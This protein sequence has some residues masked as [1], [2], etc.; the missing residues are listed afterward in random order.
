MSD[1]TN[2]KRKYTKTVATSSNIKHSTDS[3]DTEEKPSLNN[4]KEK[5]ESLC[6]KKSKDA[7][8]LLRQKFFEDLKIEEEFANIEGIKQ[9]KSPHELSS[10]IVILLRE[11]CAM[12]SQH[13]S[14]SKMLSSSTLPELLSVLSSIYGSNEGLLCDKWT[15]ME[16]V[17][18]QRHMLRAIF[19]AC[20]IVITQQN[21]VN[22]I[23]A[24]NTIAT[25]LEAASETCR[26]VD[27]HTTHPTANSSSNLHLQL[28]CDMV[29]GTLM[30]IQS[31]FQNLPFN[32]TLINSAVNLMT[33]FDENKGFVLLR[34]IFSKVDALKSV[35]GDN[36]PI[37]GAIDNPV[38]CLS[39]LI[40]TLKVTK[41]TYIHTIKCLKR[42]HRKCL[43]SHYF[44]HHHD[45]LGVAASSEPST[46][47]DVPLK[48][49]VHQTMAPPKLKCLVATWSEFLFN[50]I[51][52]VTSK[53]FQVQ[54]LSAAY[55]SGVCCCMKLSHIVTPVVEALQSEK[56]SPSVMN[57]AF[58][59]LNRVLL[60]QFGGFFGS[61]HGKRDQDICPVCLIGR[62]SSNEHLNKHMF[63]HKIILQPDSGFVSSDSGWIARSSGEGLHSKWHSLALMKQ[64]IFGKNESLAT[65][66][67][68]H[69]TLLV[70][71]GNRSLKKELFTYIYAPALKM[72]FNAN[73]E[74]AKDD[75]DKTHIP[76]AVM[77]Y[78]L[79]ALPF[80]LQVDVLMATFLKNQGLSQLSSLLA[81]DSLR[82]SVLRVFEVLIILEE[83]RIKQDNF[84]I[85]RM[86][87]NRQF[88]K[89][90]TSDS[91]DFETASGT[92]L[93][94][95]IDI[96]VDQ[97]Q[98]FRRLYLEEC[99]IGNERTQGETR[100]RTN[101][102]N[103]DKD[104]A[105]QNHLSF[106]IDIWNT[107]RTLC[108]S[109]ERF[110]HVF[111][112]SQILPLAM[113]LL[114]STLNCLTESCKDISDHSSGVNVS[115]QDSGEPTLQPPCTVFK[116]KLS[117]I[118]GLLVAIIACSPNKVC[119]LVYCTSVI[120]GSME[121]V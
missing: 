2:P 88:S 18:F 102:D 91:E 14:P 45:I 104:E 81:I 114:Q 49:G 15:A 115:L 12:D 67:A 55:A 78:C 13:V 39:M 101:S 121:I 50:L 26:M 29:F 40:N 69:L 97:T 65:L 23:N 112:E 92:V 1:D 82:L 19:T 3:E 73:H 94:A 108:I 68:K 38:Q 32:P 61:M 63:G 42:K 58:D 62:W 64:L 59:I 90:S 5:G 11:L 25:I 30:C 28:A 27:E 4:A 22:I 99:L 43:Y 34:F 41:V 105:Y 87:I 120:I 54:L 10:L 51:P 46:L 72:Y 8:I 117:L 6:F 37:M 116:N 85:K 107:C 80:F 7:P 106:I 20:G 71:K 36:C 75:G 93:K 9:P 111:G 84:K 74:K 118:E 77:I 103:N 95:F 119:T 70:V 83:Y 16:I 57:H 44:D 17:Q 33:E 79:S 66:T 60:E 89:A 100:T 31:V 76:T 48:E 86:G 98:S 24:H 96:L 109:S 35:A 47:T 21:G 53:A 56:M 52:M 113:G 110:L